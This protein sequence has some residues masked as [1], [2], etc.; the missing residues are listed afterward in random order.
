MQ[1]SMLDE[2]DMF[3]AG[4]KKADKVR[5]NRLFKRING[6]QSEAVWRLCKA[7]TVC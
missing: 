1:G 2:K 3:R 6:S 7:T 5:I 4:V